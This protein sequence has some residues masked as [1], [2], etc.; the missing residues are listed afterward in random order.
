VTRRTTDLLWALSFC[1]VLILTLVQASSATDHQRWSSVGAPPK[2]GDW[3]EGFYAAHGL[4]HDDTWY[5]GGAMYVLRAQA[6]SVGS[7]TDWSVYA[8]T[9]ADRRARA[10]RRTRM[11]EIVSVILSSPP[12]QD[13]PEK[14]ALRIR[15]QAGQ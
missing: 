11:A 4:G 7:I 15:V 12:A 9:I 2:S 5:S 10:R 1:G 6:A 14:A 13:T 8:P 3:G